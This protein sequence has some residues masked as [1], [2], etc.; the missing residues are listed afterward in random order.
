[1][2]IISSSRLVRVVKME[3]KA[4]TSQFLKKKEKCQF[5]TLDWKTVPETFVPF[6]PSNSSMNDACPLT[7][8]FDFHFDPT[9]QSVPLA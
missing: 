4:M 1:M 2:P 6:C 7:N 8:L 5:L 3:E 9:I